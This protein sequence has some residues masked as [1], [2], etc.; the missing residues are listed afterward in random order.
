MKEDLYTKLK[1]VY[2][3]TQKEIAVTVLFIAL[4]VD[5]LPDGIIPSQYDSQLQ[6]G[7]IFALSLIMVGVLFE[8]LTILKE[9]NTQVETLEYGDLTNSIFKLI[10]NERDIDIKY[11]AVAGLTG[12]PIIANMLD[13]RDAR[14][15]LHKRSVNIEVAVI[16]PQA[17]NLVEKA[18][19]RY[20]GVEN[21][22][23]EVHKFQEKLE[24]NNYKNVTLT[25]HQYDYMPN[26]IGFLVNDNYLFSTLAY[27]EVEDGT[28]NDL[29]L[30]GGRR[31][32]IVY[33][34]ND[35]F[36]G[37]FYIKRF[38][39]WFTSIKEKYGVSTPS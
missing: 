21:T 23:R 6:Q 25:L 15:Q 26:F 8:I 30:R 17:L 35:G 14:N 7:L 16:S 12:W 13:E 33:D 27:W 38:K 9:N 34:K 11:I 37:E 24:R 5:I 4:L 22:I 10:E 18:H 36:G 31:N 2:T 1:N 19:A 29:V 32:Y 20:S 3:D 28:E 39:G